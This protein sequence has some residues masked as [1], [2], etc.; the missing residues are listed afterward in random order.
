MAPQH[1][2]THQRPKRDPGQTKRTSTV[3]SRVRR[4]DS[5]GMGIG[6]RV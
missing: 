4:A 2:A 6:Y 5:L 1:G 3:R